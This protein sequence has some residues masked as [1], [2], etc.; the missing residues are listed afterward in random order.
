[1]LYV[2]IVITVVFAFSSLAMDYGRVQLAKTQLRVAADAAARAAAPA[3]GNVQ[4]VQDLA[5][6]YASMNSCD[7][8]TITIDKNNDVEFLDWDQNTRTYTVLT[9]AQ[10]NYAD[11]VRVTCKRT[12]ASGIPLMCTRVFGMSSFDVKASST[13][14]MIPPGYGLVGINYITLKGNS[15]ASYWY[16]SGT[17]GGNS[18]NIASN[19]NI[20]STG[21][22]TIKGTI[23]VPA[24]AT[25][26]GVTANAR[27]TLTSPLSYPNGSSA[28][29][30]L[31]AN[32][33]GLLPSGTV[34]SGNFTI[35]NNQTYP[36]P[37]GHYVVN[38]FSCAGT[39]N[40]QGAA[41]FYVYGTLTIAGSVN[42]HNGLPANL[43]L[44]TIPN[45]STNAAPGAVTL[46]N[47]GTI[48]A[49]I[50]APQSDITLAG[51]GAI[52]GQ[53]IGKS[54]TM[55]GSSDIYYDLSLQGGNNVI[56]VVK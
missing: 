30:N 20:T 9:G 29:Y 11:A 26:S 48:V 24:S 39:M 28:P 12:G 46:S 47:N 10:R 15:S 8:S 14:A 13:V 55:T 31:A 7:G 41:T 6:T 33:N 27:R 25:V 43:S 36:I 35:N 53:I 38:N 37:A 49:N 50:Y 44:V 52:Y 17:V 1:M 2:I 21:N 5:Y 4:N 56:Q 16:N 34:N 23:W 19:G 32:D 45:P 18:G 51:N 54:V 42:T 3:L 22:S 40:L